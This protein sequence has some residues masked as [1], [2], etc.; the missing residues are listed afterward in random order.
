VG[1]R[2]LPDRAFGGLSLRNEWCPSGS[3]L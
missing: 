1:K 2:S 3:P